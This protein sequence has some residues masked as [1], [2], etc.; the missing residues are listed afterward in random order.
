M[1]RKDDWTRDQ[2]VKA[3]ALYCQLP[4]GQ[5]DA[6]TPAVKA[7]ATAI[8]RT[9]GAIAYKL[10]NF[11]S[12]DPY[13]KNRGVKGMANSSKADREIWAEYYGRWELLADHA[14]VEVAKISAEMVQPSGPTEVVALTK[15]RRGQQFFRDAVFAG[16]Q[17]TCC[18]TGI[19]AR[20]LLR[21][22][23]IVPWKSDASLRLN[24]R[25]GLCLN[26]LH[27]AAF[28]RGLISLTHDLTL[29]VSTKLRREVPATVYREMFESRE[30][31][32]L[33]I[34]PRYCP[35]PEILAFHSKTLF[36]D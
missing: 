30:G 2:I 29:R 17:N 4:F 18:I 25:N 20:P 21:A 19:T 14:V 34:P 5:M 10:A 27:D 22:S 35:T 1:A 7:L 32:K 6:R 26:A 23:H 13:H 3:I 24:P 28:D 16:H 33:S 36:R 11:A 12:L 31:R 15:Q 8:G 9:P